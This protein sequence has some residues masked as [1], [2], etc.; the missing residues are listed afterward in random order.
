MKR[1]RS[2]LFEYTKER[3]IFLNQKIDKTWVSATQTRNYILNDTI[4]DWLNLYGGSQGFK[5]DSESNSIIQ[6]SLNFTRYIMNKGI[7]FEDL[8][9]SEIK[10]EHHIYRVNRDDSISLQERYVLQIQDT[11]SAMKR[12]EKI[13]YQGLVF[14]PVSMTF[15]YPD[16]IIRSDCINSLV[17]TKILTEKKANKPCSFSSEW[18]YRIIDV[19]F[20]TLALDISKKT[21]LNKGSIKCYKAQLYIYNR[22]L[23]YMQFFIPRKAY[24]LGRGIERTKTEEEVSTPFTTLGQVDFYGKDKFIREESNRAV[25]WI[26]E[27]RTKGKNWTVFPPSRKE[28]YPNMCNEMDYDWHKTKC[29][30]AEELGEITLLWQCGITHRNIAHKKG[31]YSFYEK[32]IS[33]DKIGV[34][35]SFSDNVDRIIKINTSR[36]EKKYSVKKDYLREELAKIQDDIVSLFVDLETASN[37]NRLDT[38]ETECCIFMI[39]AGCIDE[40]ENWDF[41]CF[42]AD[43]LTSEEERKIVNSFLEYLNTVATNKKVRLFHYSPAEPIRFN[44]ILEKHKITPTVDITWTDLLEI[45]KSSSLVVKGAF[46]YSLKSVVSALS[47]HNIIKADYKSCEVNNGSQAMIASFISNELV[48]KGEV[49]SMNKCE[50][51]DYVRK[52]N[53]I[54]CQTLHNLLEALSVL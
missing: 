6:S 40:K 31:L 2:S 11:Y 3:E 20:S 52:Y 35:E 42:T 41:K 5:R 39:G 45:I 22:A 26:R 23:G 4:L 12:G 54:D 1:K 17:K 37:I 49:T 48:N 15:G 47:F 14:D 13:I 18:H 7:E 24:I 10:K 16:L 30:I 36:K 19:K 53:E 9:I 51:M 44:Q 21:L 27:L 46:N 28:L 50:V 32:K 33:A 38:L 34:K 8:I 25:E 43:K 29:K